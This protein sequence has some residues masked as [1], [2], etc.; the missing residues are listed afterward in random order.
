M[1]AADEYGNNLCQL[2]GSLWD[3]LDLCFPLL[4]MLAFPPVAGELLML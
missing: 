1:S 3:P 4:K 2:S